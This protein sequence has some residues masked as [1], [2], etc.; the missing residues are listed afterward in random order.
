MRQ[1]LPTTKFGGMWDG[2]S[3]GSVAIASGKRLL[4][5]GDHIIPNNLTMPA[6]AQAALHRGH[7]GVT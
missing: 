2:L 1:H 4:L 3:I 7:P 6:R 5:P